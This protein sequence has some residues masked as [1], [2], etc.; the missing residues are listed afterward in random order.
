MHRRTRRV[1]V[2]INDEG[3][4]QLPCG[5]TTNPLD[6]PIWYVGVPHEYVSFAY[7][8]MPDGRVAIHSA[9]RS[10][11]NDVAEDFLYEIVERHEAVATAESMVQDGIAWLLEHNCEF[12]YNEIAPEFIEKLEQELYVGLH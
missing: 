5:K 10:L 11:E 9:V 1:K 8:M 7:L 3:H 4:V 2:D 6:E 12:D